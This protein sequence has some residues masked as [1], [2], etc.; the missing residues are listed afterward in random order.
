MLCWS[1]VVVTHTGLGMMID[2]I[3]YSDS[4]RGT[5]YLSR[6]RIQPNTLTESEFKQAVKDCLIVELLNVG[7]LLIPIIMGI[8]LLYNRLVWDIDFSYPGWWEPVRIVATLIAGEIWFYITHRL[9]HHHELYASIHKVHHRFTAPICLSGLYAHPIEF[10]FGNILS[11]HIGTI[12][13]RPH[14]IF[15]LLLSVLAAYYNVWAHS[16]YHIPDKKYEWLCNASF[17]DSHHRLFTKNYGFS[18]Y[19]DKLFGT[20]AKP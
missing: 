16:G 2:Y 5:S 12:L 7:L 20:Y 10:V 18:P 13:F 17:H 15:F 19:L 3:T 4:Y 6:Y 14:P 1:L 8:V 11:I 9:M